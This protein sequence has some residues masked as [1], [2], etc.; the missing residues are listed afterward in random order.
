MSITG[1][2]SYNSNNVEGTSTSGLFNDLVQVPI[3]TNNI[4]ALQQITTGISYSDVSSV[5]M[6]T[7][8]NNLTITSSP[9]IHAYI[10]SKFLVSFFSSIIY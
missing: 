2:K 5:D 1:S 10:K 8:S 4:I 6:T 9:P 7:I 3:N